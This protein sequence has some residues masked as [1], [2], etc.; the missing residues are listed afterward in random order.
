[1]EQLLQGFK[2][3]WYGSHRTHKSLENLMTHIKAFLISKNLTDLSVVTAQMVKDY[4]AELKPKCSLPKWNQAI[5]A[6]R[7]FLVDWGKVSGLEFPKQKH[8]L[9]KNKSPLTLDELITLESR[10][11]CYFPNTLQVKAILYFLYFTGIEK[12]KLPNIRRD[13]IRIGLRELNY[14]G[15]RIPLHENLIV[16]LQKYFGCEAEET[17]GVKEPNAFNTS[18]A[19]INHIFKVLQKSR[20]LGEDRVIGPK[21]FRAGFANHCFKKGISLFSIQQLM[22]NK[23][24]KTTMSYLS[25]EVKA[26][27]LKKF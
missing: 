6:L 15:N 3:F 26:D 2:K 8:P 23:D 5:W 17:Y 1:M 27:F 14:N 22:R 20:L 12:S 13:D 7:V 25:D 21:E 18:I 19:K 10:L 11:I 24:I 16:L 9:K 4:F